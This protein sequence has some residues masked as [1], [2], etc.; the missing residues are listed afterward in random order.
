MQDNQN[1]ELT[2]TFRKPTLSLNCDSRLK[3]S[4]AV[5]NLCFSSVLEDNCSGNVAL[6]RTQQ[7]T[8]FSLPVITAHLPKS[9]CTVCHYLCVR[10]LFPAVGFLHLA[11]RSEEP[12]C[13]GGLE[14]VLHHERQKPSKVSSLSAMASVSAGRYVF[15][16]PGS[17]RAHLLI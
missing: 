16:S 11:Q 1:I 9:C 3:F 2:A 10:P 7:K 5:L 13:C 14:A 6:G 8:Q 15:T 4:P 17:F 12:R